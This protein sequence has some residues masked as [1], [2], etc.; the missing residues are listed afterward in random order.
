MERPFAVY[1]A[2]SSMDNIDITQSS[3]NT[4]TCVFVHEGRRSRL[5]GA[6]WIVLAPVSGAGQVE[7]GLVPKGFST[8]PKTIGTLLYQ[9]FTT[10][11]ISGPR[12][13]ANAT[14][15]ADAVAP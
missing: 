11:S 4:C 1:I 10:I 2:R 12:T 5:G 14:V 7:D 9:A 6:R 3:V 8:H 13:T 15:F